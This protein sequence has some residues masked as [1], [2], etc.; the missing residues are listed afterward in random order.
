M[1]TYNYNFS[2]SA[3]SDDASLS[4]GKEWNKHKYIK[5]AKRPGYTRYYYT[6]G[7]PKVSPDMYGMSLGYR[8]GQYQK[9]QQD[10]QYERDH[11]AGR[12]NR[13]YDQYFSD[14]MKTYEQSPQY[15]KDAAAYLERSGNANRDKK[16]DYRNI[17]SFQTENVEEARRSE[18]ETKEE[19]RRRL[20]ETG[21][22]VLNYYL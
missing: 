21:K 18:E 10:L 13:T 12:D 9:D 8:T 2:Q 7:V 17:P 20:M 1:W 22:S 11:A 19:R 4:H 14:K 15:E 5:K 16:R 3:I 6:P